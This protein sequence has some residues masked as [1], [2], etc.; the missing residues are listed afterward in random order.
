ME[1]IRQNAKTILLTDGGNPSESLIRSTGAFCVPTNTIDNFACMVYAKNL[2][3]ARSTFG[4]AAM[5]VSPVPKRFWAFDLKHFGIFGSYENCVPTA[6][7]EEITT[8][9]TAS[10]RQKR[11][12]QTGFCRFERIN[13]LI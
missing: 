2:V 7:Y 12:I 13:A 1:I 6:D 11:L 10:S 4:Y 3:L 8:N 9:W 5:W